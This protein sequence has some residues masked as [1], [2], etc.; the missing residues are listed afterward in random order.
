MMKLRSRPQHCKSFPSKIKGKRNGVEGFREGKER[1]NLAMGKFFMCFST[2]SCCVV[3]F[4][5][6]HLRFVVEGNKTRVNS[7][8]FSPQFCWRNFCFSV[9]LFCTLSAPLARSFGDCFVV[10]VSLFSFSPFGKF[11][12]LLFCCVFLFYRLLSDTTREKIVN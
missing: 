1:F 8:V 9:L 2:F 3:D 7:V 10:V 5:F 4:I 12:L 6:Y 11:F